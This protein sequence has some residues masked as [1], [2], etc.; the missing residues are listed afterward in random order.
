MNSTR[1]LLQPFHFKLPRVISKVP[2]YLLLFTSGLLI[3]AVNH[4]AGLQQVL[5]ANTAVNAAGVKS[6]D[7]IDRIYEQTDDLV[8]DYRLESKRLEDLKIYNNQL[9]KQI[10]NQLKAIEELSHSIDEITIVE[11]QISPLL[12]RMIDS[13]ETF[14]SLDIPFL[15]KE[16]QE[17]IQFLKTTMNRGDV[18]A[19]EQFRLVFEA[20]Q[21][22]NGY[23]SDIERYKG[24]LKLSGGEK[25]VNFLRIGRLALIYQTFD[26]KEQG[27]WDHTKKSWE[28][29]GAEYQ[30]SIREGLKVAGE[31]VAP[32]LIVLPV[33]AAEVL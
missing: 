26:G 31:Q 33:Q 7:K 14:V 9:Q 12:L 22:E 19:A 29:L 20:Y 23:G 16:R 15:P 11:R 28:P 13:L 5:G 6:Q 25:E 30:T 17:R 2:L 27:H 18:T 21:I 3:S 1:N 24:R 8:S 32:D 4:A 10:D